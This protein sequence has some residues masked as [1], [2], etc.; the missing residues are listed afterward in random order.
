MEIIFQNI[1]TCGFGNIEKL[2]TAGGNILE[3]YSRDTGAR[4]HTKNE[5]HG[6]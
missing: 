3:Y 6:G 5:W 1:G 2:K 4:R